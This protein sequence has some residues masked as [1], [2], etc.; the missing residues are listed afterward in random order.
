[1]DK[2]N[3][4]TSFGV[5]KPVD[6]VVLALVNAASAQAVADELQLQG[7]GSDDITR[8]TPQEM[9]NQVDSNLVTASGLASLGQDLNLVKA[10][11]ALGE[12]GCSFLVVHAP[13]SEQVKRI[14]AIANRVKA[15]S[16]Q[17]YGSLVVE[18][19]LDSEIDVRQVFESPDRGLDSDAVAQKNA[20]ES[21]P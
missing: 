13:E 12:E 18:E 7:F 9:I 11:R 19:L 2:T 1:M 8:Y 6:H 5:F 17:R 4:P 14:Q 15:K 16:A 20:A 21:A 10:H 3:P